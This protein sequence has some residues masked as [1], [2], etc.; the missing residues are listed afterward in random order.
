MPIFPGLRESYHKTCFYT[1]QQLAAVFISWNQA[2]LRMHCLDPILGRCNS[3]YMHS[4]RNGLSTLRLSTS[5][6][7]LSFQPILISPP[8]P[9][10]TR[11]S[12]SSRTPDGY[13]T[14][15]REESRD[16]PARSE[17]QVVD[18]LSLQSSPEALERETCPG[19]L[20]QTYQTV[21]KTD[22]EHGVANGTSVHLRR[23]PPT[24]G[25]SSASFRLPW[26]FTYKYLQVLAIRKY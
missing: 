2:S 18:P 19:L 9:T 6:F 14:A 21:L 23:L 5:S 20:I 1:L 11:S 13:Q 17:R 25:S 26:V 3:V 4:R 16:Q 8:S 10:P 22:R 12:S 24:A 15:V 7:S